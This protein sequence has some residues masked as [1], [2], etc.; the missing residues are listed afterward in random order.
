MAMGLSFCGAVGR[1]DNGMQKACQLLSNP[2]QNNLLFL[3]IF[4]K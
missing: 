4:F 2:Y 1:Q 3:F